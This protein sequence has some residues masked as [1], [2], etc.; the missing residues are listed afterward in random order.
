MC[1]ISFEMSITQTTF[2]FL[3][4]NALK[5]KSSWSK[6]MKDTSTIATL[7]VQA[8]W[9][10][11]SSWKS[12]RHRSILIWFLTLKLTC[13]MLLHPVQKDSKMSRQNQRKHQ[14]CWPMASLQ[15]KKTSKDPQ[16]KRDVSRSVVQ[17]A[18]KN[19]CRLKPWFEF[20]QAWLKCTESKNSCSASSVRSNISWF[21][22]S[23]AMKKSAKVTW[24]LF[25]K[26][27]VW[28][29]RRQRCL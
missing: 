21:M 10:L 26:K 17:H 1:R 6:F 2:S 20:H 23:T 5:L 29:F 14:L 16:S 11:L 3:E 25:L 4:L 12:L 7:S 22:L 8:L 18:L 27:L 24:L 9:M 13:Q 19:R 15:F 28:S